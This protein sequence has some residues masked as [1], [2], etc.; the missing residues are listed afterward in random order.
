MN[1]NHLEKCSVQELIS[2][3][4]VVVLAKD[5][6]KDCIFFACVI[7]TVVSKEPLDFRVLS[8]GGCIYVCE[9]CLGNVVALKNEASTVTECT[10]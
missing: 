2:W 3:R 5:R 10:D 1:V 6:G 8:S 9:I 7:A 4:G